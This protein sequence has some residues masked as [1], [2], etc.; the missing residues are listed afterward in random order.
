MRLVNPHLDGE[1][2]FWEAGPIGIVL[3]H[4]FTATP[5]EVRPLAKRL[6]AEGYTVAGPL[7]P[8]HATQPE[9]LNRVLWKDWVEAYELSLRNTLEHCERVFIG[10]ESTGA[11]LAMYL[12]TDY[13]QVLGVLAYAPALRLQMSPWDRIRLSISAPF[14]KFVPKR[15][16]DGNAL[17][18]GYPV[19]PLRGVL[20]LHSLQKQVLRRLP[21]IHQPILVIQ[22]RRDATVH[23]DVPD[24]IRS[25]SGGPVEIH[26]MDQSSHVVILEG[27]LDAITRLTLEFIQMRLS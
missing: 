21:S 16:P 25:Q 26:W 22:G 27:E 3:S 7:L 12:A 23:P 8:G 10:G 18:Q 15:D 1:P 6:H 13:P 20:Q 17:W 5:A 2:F 9:D 14:V 19:N 4:G 24:L 11:L